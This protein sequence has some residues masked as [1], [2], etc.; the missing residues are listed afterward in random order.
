MTGSVVTAI[1]RVSQIESS[2]YDD[3]LDNKEFTFGKKDDDGPYTSWD[4]LS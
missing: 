1:E 4:S 2:I 3:T